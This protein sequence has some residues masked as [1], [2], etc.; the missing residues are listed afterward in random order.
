MK[1]PPK[2]TSPIPDDFVI[3]LDD[4]TDADFT[5]IDFL[6]NLLPHDVWMR[7]DYE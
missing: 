1:N 5:G 7:D 2:K 3:G 4:E 6:E